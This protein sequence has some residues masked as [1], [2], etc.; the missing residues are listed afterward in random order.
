M[1]ES[2]SDPEDASGDAADSSVP[3]R[4]EPPDDEATDRPLRTARGALQAM[5]AAE[6][7]G[8]GGGNDDD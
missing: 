6:A 2:P 3:D 4:L 7:T 1:S 8:D 5:L